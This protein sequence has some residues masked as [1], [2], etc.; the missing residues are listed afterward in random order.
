MNSAV[1]TEKDYQYL[2]AARRQLLFVFGGVES[3]LKSMSMH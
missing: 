1:K 3:G 2:N